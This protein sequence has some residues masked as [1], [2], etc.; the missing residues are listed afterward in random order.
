MSSSPR[1][2]DTSLFDQ[3]TA[4]SEDFYR[5]VN[6]GWLDANPVPPEYGAWGAFHEVN[7]RNEALLHRLLKAA[8]DDDSPS[9]TPARMAGDYF[10]A[11]MDEAAITAA[12]V[13]PL[14]PFLRASM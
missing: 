3:A 13:T 9:G 11:A 7:Q 4:A 6:G 2:I 5:H 8:A 10:A 14:D 12:G 1:A